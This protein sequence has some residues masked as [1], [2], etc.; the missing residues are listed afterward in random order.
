MIRNSGFSLRN[1]IVVFVVLGIMLIAGSLFDYELSCAVFNST[2]P[3]A[4]VFAG[5]GQLPMVLAISGSAAL[6]WHKGIVAKVFAVILELFALMGVIADPLINIKGMNIIL[7]VL[8]GLI[9]V[10]LNTYFFYNTGKNKDKKVLNRY[11]ATLLIVTFGSLILV[12]VVKI[13]WQRPRMR[14]IA[15]TPVA[16]F[17]NWWVRGCKDYELLKGLGVVSEEFKSFPSGH[18]ANA[19]IM[20]LLGSLPLLDDKFKS[21]K[22]M[23]F[24]IGFGFAL[25]VAFSRIVAGAHFLSDV[26]MGIFITFVFEIIVLKIIWR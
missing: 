16:S 6:L 21:K 14:M 10:G 12:N 26:T 7:I 9:I 22:N 11:I 23:L 25:V 8:I 4:L 18:A 17:Q 24:F 3:F 15:I 2:N 20:I 5:Y 13:F 1:C 19:A